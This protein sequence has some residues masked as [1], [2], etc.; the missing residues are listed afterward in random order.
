MGA[1][2]RGLRLR[3]AA[4]EGCAT[5][6][7]PSMRS[8]YPYLPTSKR[9]GASR[10]FPQTGSSGR[11]FLRS[12]ARCRI[13]S[14]TRKGAAGKTAQRSPARRRLTSSRPPRSPSS[15]RPTCSHGRSCSRRV[16]GR[17]SGSIVRRPRDGQRSDVASVEVAVW[18]GIC[19]LGGHCL[20]PTAEPCESALTF[21]FR[22]RR[23]QLLGR[24]SLRGEPG[25]LALCVEGGYRP[26]A[27][28]CGPGGPRPTNEARGGNSTPVGGRAGG[29]NSAA[30]AE[31]S[32][33]PP[34]ALS[35]ETRLIA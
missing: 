12:C 30:A 2:C 20:S 19:G 13:G 14:A 24:V 5:P 11:P 34:P 9:L 1:P 26:R 17:G 21:P 25:A 8:L 35:T 22:R 3:R 23:I 10:N 31:W 7:H 28:F 4:R 6:G 32:D 29:G 27:E 15:C 18:A 33:Q 16:A